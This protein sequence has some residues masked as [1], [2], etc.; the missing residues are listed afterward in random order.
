MIHSLINKSAFVGLDNV[1]HFATGG[2][3]PMLRSHAD[4]VQQFMVDKGQGEPARGLQDDILSEVAEQ[5]ASLFKVPA[6]DLTFL[7][8]ATEG[9]NVLRYALEWHAGD[10]VVVA[11]VEFPSDILPWTTL[12]NLGVEVRVVKHRD[13]VI[14]EDDLLAMVDE[15]TR[16][17]AISQVSMFTGQ[18]M[19]VPKLSKAVR[20]KGAVFLLDATH[21]AGVV[22]VDANYADIMVCSCYKWLLGT[23]GAAVFYCNRETMASLSPPFLGW[24][25][26]SSSGGWQ[27]PLEFTLSANADRFLSANPS[28]ISLHILN[29]GLKY[30]LDL[31][32]ERIHD[33]CLQLSKM[34]YDGI[35]S[36]GL[37]MMTP[38]ADAQRAGNTCFMVDNVEAL[39]SSLGDKGVLVWGAYGN[40]GRL[41]VSTHVHNDSADVERL[42]EAMRECTTAA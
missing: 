7:S 27:A 8:S 30:L 23:H 22:P 39:R 28:Y 13:W 26:P 19:D 15:R 20:T 37:E 21:A 9:I 2:E 32:E 24:A 10:N 3:S 38:R 1:A 6:N 40:F 5:C 12:Q 14:E 17:V 18:R 29:N 11:D 4:A 34:V 33:H 16:V 36:L 35:A 25:S 31:G 42:L 41:R